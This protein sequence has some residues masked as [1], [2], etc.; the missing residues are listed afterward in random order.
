[1]QMHTPN[2]TPIALIAESIIQEDDPKHCD[3]CEKLVTHYHCLPG[4]PNTPYW[5]HC[6][7][8]MDH[9]K[10]KGYL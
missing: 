7:D 8:C 4:S 3:S 9:F 6:D 1:M 2:Y 5:I 10:L